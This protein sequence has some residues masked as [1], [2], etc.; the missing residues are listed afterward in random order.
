MKKE[1]I[2]DDNNIRNLKMRNN[3]SIR[4]RHKVI[5]LYRLIVKCIIIYSMI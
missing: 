2:T 3:K 1:I 5:K 4:K